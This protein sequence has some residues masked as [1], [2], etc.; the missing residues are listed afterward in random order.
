MSLLSGAASPDFVYALPK[1]VISF[2]EELTC[3]EKILCLSFL[4][5]P[6]L[7]GALIP[8]LET[9]DWAPPGH[10]GGPVAPFC[11]ALSGHRMLPVQEQLFQLAPLSTA[12]F[13]ARQVRQSELPYLRI[14]VVSTS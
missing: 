11:Q 10:R 7:S 6:S 3:G 14:T 4:L 12:H 5:S 1:L 9:V 8:Y 13:H 2:W